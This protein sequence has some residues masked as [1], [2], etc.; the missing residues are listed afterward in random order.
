MSL[1]PLLAISADN[2]PG[3][4]IVGIIIVTS[5]V[6]QLRGAKKAYDKTVVRQR[7]E[8][9]AA[10]AQPAVYPRPGQPVATPQTAAQARALLVSQIETVAARNAAAAQ[11][12]PAQSA[13]VQQPASVPQQSAAPSQQPVYRRPAAPQQ[14]RAVYRDPMVIG[15]SASDAA[16]AMVDRSFATLPTTL[17]SAQPSGA[18]LTGTA[19]GARSSTRRM[20]ATAFGDPAHARSSV[21]L[22]EVLGTPVGL[23]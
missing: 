11:R 12:A 14:Q 4:V 20:L 2:L 7:A 3:L 10:S 15:R 9:D 1:V 6:N 22:A 18:L 23:R 17:G 13:S 5:I 16:A 8:R 19:T 21:I